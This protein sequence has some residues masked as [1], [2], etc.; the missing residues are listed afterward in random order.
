[1]AQRVMIGMMVA[2]G[3]ELL[4]ADEPTT[5]LDVTIQAQIFEL[6]DEIQSDTGMSVL[7]ITHD[8]GVVA[9]NCDRVVVMQLGRVVE[10]APVEKL[11]AE[12]VHPYTRR[13]LGAIL[14]PDRPP[15]PISDMPVL[16]ASAS[17]SA[18]GASYQAKSVDAWTEEEHG[19]AALIEIAPGHFVAG[20]PG[21]AA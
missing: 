10:I 2:C 11:F 15:Q 16:P 1:M 20:H 12:P 3:A 9:E 14:W 5:G 21:V 19:A 13:L 6:L 18:N 8:L 4:I 17:F 7:L